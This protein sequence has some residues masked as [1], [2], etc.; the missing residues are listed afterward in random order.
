MNYRTRRGI[1]KAGR[2]FFGKC[3]L[4]LGDADRP[5]PAEKV[6]DRWFVDRHL[7]SPDITLGRIP[8]ARDARSRA[9]LRSMFSPGWA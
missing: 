8:E 3:A 1:F 4:T 2:H 6:G 7:Q 5:S 9:L